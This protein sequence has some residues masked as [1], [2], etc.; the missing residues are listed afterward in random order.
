MVIYCHWSFVVSADVTQLAVY[1]GWND[2]GEPPAPLEEARYLS[3]GSEEFDCLSAGKAGLSLEQ[4]QL[5]DVYSSH[6]FLV[7]QLYS[8]YL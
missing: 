1:S 3:F 8:Q 6:L 4:L 5:T 7:I 2:S